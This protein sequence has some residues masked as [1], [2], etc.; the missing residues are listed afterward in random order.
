VSG[1]GKSTIAFDIIFAEG[2]RRYLESLNAYAR[3]FV[4]P[5]SRPDVDAVFGIPPTVAIEQRTSRGGLR[6]TVGTLTEIHHF[7]RLLFVKLGIQFCP[8]HQQPVEP[9]SHDQIAQR[10]LDDWRGQRVT[11]LAPLVVARKGIYKEL[12]QWAGRKGHIILRVDGQP[13]PTDDWP[14][15]ERYQ[16]H[17][18]DLPVADL[19][20]EDPAELRLALEEALKHGKGIIRVAAV[21]QEGNWGEERAYSTHRACTECGSAFEEPDPRLFSYNSKYG[22]CPRCLGTGILKPGMDEEQSGEE[23]AY[24]SRD[25]NEPD[26]VCPEC[27]GAR[28]R[29]EA[30]AVRFHGHSIASLSALGVDQAHEFFAGLVLADREAAIG[31]DVVSEIQGRLGFLKQVGLGYLSLDRAAPSLSGGEAQRI[32]LAAQLGSN[33]QGVCYV[34]DEPTIGLHPRDNK[35]LLDTLQGLERKGN[36]VVVVEHDEETIRRAEHIIDLGPGAGVQGGRVVAQGTLDDL[37]N[38]PESLTGACLKQAQHVN[39]DTRDEAVEHHLEVIGASANNLQGIDVSFPINRLV[40]VTGVSG[41]GKS[42]LVREVLGQSVRDLLNDLE[43]VHGA[44]KLNGW[45]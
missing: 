36:S 3:Q 18:I 4:Q 31:K 24:L 5:A 27:H 40:C 6:S 38:A 7:L 17:N 16:E 11:L 32:R 23:D 35:L 13:A 39:I 37:M 22:W 9:L 15:L 10:I 44:K 30:L 2:Q 34:L 28:L 33:L 41:S 26:R 14:K 20:P 12:A 29:P 21:D 43:T 45:S 1:S 19:V 42:T 8:E 25:E